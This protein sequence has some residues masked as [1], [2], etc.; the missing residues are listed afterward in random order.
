VFIIFALGR[1]GG[2]PQSP[3]APAAGPTN[4]GLKKILAS[5]KP[6]HPLSRARTLMLKQARVVTN[7]YYKS[8]EVRPRH[9]IISGANTNAGTSRN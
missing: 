7:R 6:T 9:L 3:D 2:P 5:P 4:L 1:L 8:Q